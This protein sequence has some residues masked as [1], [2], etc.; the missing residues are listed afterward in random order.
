MKGGLLKID[1]KIVVPS[2]GEIE[3]VNMAHDSCA[4]YVPDVLVNEVA[5]QVKSLLLRPLVVNGEE[6][7]IP[8]DVE[9]GD[10]L[11]TLEKF[12]EAA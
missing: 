1:E 12:K 6:F 11:G 3:L 7:T 10:S 9:I 8:V 5:S 2:N 4:L